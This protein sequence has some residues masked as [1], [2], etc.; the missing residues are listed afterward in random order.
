MK[1]RP[2][3]VIFTGPMFSSKT[4]RLL[5]ELEK[6]KYQKKNVIAFKPFIDTRYNETQ[7]TTHV[8]LTHDAVCVN[9]GADILKF[10]SDS[11]MK[12]DVIAVDEA[13]MIKGVAEALTFLYRNGFSVYVSSLELASNCTVFREVEKMLPWATK[14]EKRVSVCTVCGSDAYYTYKK[15]FS[16]EILEIGGDELY[17]PRCWL[18]HPTVTI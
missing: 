15:A 7:I 12:Y 3:F 11:E 10:I 9:D 5:M 8:G 2:E 16:D 4:S 18:H 1:K 14:I 17:E 13:F 6:C